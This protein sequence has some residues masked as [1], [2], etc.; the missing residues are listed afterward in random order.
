MCI[1]WTIGHV[2]VPLSFLCS[3]QPCFIMIEAGNY[4]IKRISLLADTIS[5]G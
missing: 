4:V 2:V 5:K 3:Y 1:G